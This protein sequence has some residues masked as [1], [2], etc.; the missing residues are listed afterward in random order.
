MSNMNFND[1]FKDL[2]I[3]RYRPSTLDDLVLSDRNRKYFEQ[4][5]RKGQIPHIMFHGSPGIGKSTLAKII[6]EDL[7]DCQYIYIN[8]SEES[9]V[10]VIRSKVTNFAK[11][12]SIDGKLKV[13]IL[14]EIDGLSGSKSSQGTNAQKALRNVIEEYSD[15]TRFI[16]TCNYK[17]LVMEALDS[18]FQEFDLTP[19]LDKCTERI[20]SIIT[21]ENVSIDDENKDKLKDIIR[22]KYPDIRKIIGE[23]EKNVLDGK[24]IFDSNIDKFE[25]AKNIIDMIKADKVIKV[26]PYMIK[27]SVSFNNDYLSLLRDTFDVIYDDKLDLEKKKAALLIISEAMASHNQVMDVEIN[28]YACF[29][30]L[31]NL[32]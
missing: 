27:N 17:N 16:A 25:T 26:R 13:I 18:R 28:A 14:D 32:L 15:N 1:I 20:L 22:N 21:N 2:W 8:A 12:R 31:S 30:E 11:T 10:D 19:P 6:V 7:L 29:L 5:K 3:E 24:L 4:F 9:G 23:V